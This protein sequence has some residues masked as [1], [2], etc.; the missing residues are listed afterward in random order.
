AVPMTDLAKFPGAVS[1]SW[2]SGFPTVAPSGM[3]WL[4]GAQWGP[5]QGALALATLKDSRLRVQFYSGTAFSG[6][7]IPAQFDKAYGRLRT[8]QQGPNGCLYVLTGNGSNDVI[9]Q[10]CPS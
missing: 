9:V 3:T 1:A 10:A 4:T 8:A 6:E 5:W 2:A 7:Q